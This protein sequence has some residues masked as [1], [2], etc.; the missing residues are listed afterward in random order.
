MPQ[1]ARFDVA[2]PTERIDQPSVVDSKKTVKAVLDEAGVNV[3]RFARFE[4]GQ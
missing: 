1:H 3:K 4:I 2:H